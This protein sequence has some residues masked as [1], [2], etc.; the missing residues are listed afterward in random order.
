MLY[1]KSYKLPY[2]VS[3]PSTSFKDWNMNYNKNLIIDMERFD[4]I[5]NEII[6]VVEQKFIRDLRK[7]MRL[8]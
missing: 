6:T 1:L 4:L 2:G 8:V 7:L 5:A 3:A